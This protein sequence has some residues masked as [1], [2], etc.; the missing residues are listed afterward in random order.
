MY[1]TVEGGFSLAVGTCFADGTEGPFCTEGF[2]LLVRQRSRGR[3]IWERGFS[4]GI[5]LGIG[6]FLGG[7]LFLLFCP[8]SLVGSIVFL[9]WNLYH[10]N[11]LPPFYRLGA[12]RSKSY[13]F[14][15]VL[16][17]S[18]VFVRVGP[19]SDGRIPTSSLN[20]R[21]VPSRD[22]GLVRERCVLVA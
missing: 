8:P 10:S 16:C 20:V 2:E 1:P 4:D 7:A 14:L 19:G 15:V 13:G 6:L 17:W 3:L 18:C 11:S 22:G 12:S 5:V 9:V 21:A